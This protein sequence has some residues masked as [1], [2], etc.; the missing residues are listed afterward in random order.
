MRWLPAGLWLAA[1][2]ISGFTAWRHLD[3]FDEGL[4]LVAVDRIVAGQWPYADF[5]W[6]YGPG[7]PLVLSAAAEVLGPSVVWWR[8]LRTAADATVAVLVFALVDRSAGRRWALAAWLAAALT[9][10]QPTTANP[11]PVAFAFALGAV[12][13]AVHRR[14]VAAGALVALAAAWRIDF[15]LVAAVAVLAAARERRA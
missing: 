5:A 7:H 8:V 11:F 1:A 2:L 6:A 13:A 14:P 15:G 4:L 9:M 12:L 10:A 3:P